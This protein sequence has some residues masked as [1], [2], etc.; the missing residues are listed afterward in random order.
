MADES[1]LSPAAAGAAS[2]QLPAARPGR[3]IADARHR[4]IAESSDAAARPVGPLIVWGAGGHGKVVADL[5][6]AAGGRTL[7]FV[8]ADPDKLGRE[9]E[10]GGGRVVMTADPTAR[11]EARPRRANAGSAHR[12]DLAGVGL[13]P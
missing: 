2:G 5:V 13:S 12:S 9:V 6:R 4:P 11:R 10:P 1:P 3:P 8:D 7:G